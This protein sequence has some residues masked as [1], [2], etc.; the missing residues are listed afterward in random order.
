MPITYKKKIPYI[1]ILFLTLISQ[2]NAQNFDIQKWDLHQQ[3]KIDSII[4]VFEDSKSL[5]FL[6]LAP[7]VSY[8]AFNNSFSVG[9]SLSSLSNYFQQRKRN[10]IQLAR[11]EAQL[12]AEKRKLSNSILLDLQKFKAAKIAFQNSLPIYE[13]DKKLFAISK[14]KYKNNEI[15]TADFLRLK[16]DFLQKTN[17]LKTELQRLKIQAKKFELQTKSEALTASL[18]IFTNLIPNNDEKR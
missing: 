16:K 15:T 4:Q 9:I 14:G 10:K 8:D 11:L 2:L 12:L 13:I 18:L 17:E 6:S 7:S 1:F 3:K 5:K